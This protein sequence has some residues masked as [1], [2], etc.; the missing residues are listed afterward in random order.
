M[1][2]VQV[3]EGDGVKP[4]DQTWSCWRY[5]ISLTFDS[6]L[7]GGANTAAEFTMRADA[8]AFLLANGFDDERA[9]AVLDLA[10]QRYGTGTHPTAYLE[11]NNCTA[12][13]TADKARQL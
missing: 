3:Y 8:K 7:T 11:Q 4:E 12:E 10:E 9:D 5:D 2:W 6:E 1:S 13:V